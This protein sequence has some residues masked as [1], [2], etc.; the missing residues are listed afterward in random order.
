MK[1]PIVSGKFKPA[2]LKIKNVKK[3]VSQINIF[4]KNIEYTQ[5]DELEKMG[6]FDLVSAI[7]GVLGLFLGVSFLS[8]AELIEILLELMLSCYESR[9]SRKVNK[10]KTPILKK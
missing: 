6:L 2:D 10:I 1:N 5:L 8:F 3:S 9:K 4:Y 7:G